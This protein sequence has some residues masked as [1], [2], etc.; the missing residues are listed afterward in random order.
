MSINREELQNNPLH[1]LKLED[2]VQELVDHYG[3]NILDTAMRFNCFH[4]NPS[5]ASSVKY[6]RKS[7]WAREKLEAFYLSRFKRMPRPTEEEKEMPPRMRTFANGIEPREP[8]EL[9]VDSILASQAKAASAFKEKK[10][11]ERRNRSRR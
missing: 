6:L 5:V 11:Q 2:M 9:T 7:E 1:G 3:W 10:A 4:T 8:M